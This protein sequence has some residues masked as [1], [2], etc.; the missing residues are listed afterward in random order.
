MKEFPFLGGQQDFSQLF[1]AIKSSPVDGKKLMAIHQK[2]LEILGKVSALTTALIQNASKRNLDVMREAFSGL[3]PTENG[4][5]SGAGIAKANPG[6]ILQ[7]SQKIMERVM[8]H[9]SELTEETVSNQRQAMSMLNE[10]FTE[11]SQEM[12]EVVSSD[13]GKNT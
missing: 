1:S 2:N 8:N 3:A 7:Q 9:M 5:A 6:E 10:R 12:K 13:G 4:K 11:M